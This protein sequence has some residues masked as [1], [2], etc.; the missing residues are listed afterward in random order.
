MLQH[1]PDGAAVRGATVSVGL[2]IHENCHSGLGKADTGRSRELEGSAHGPL[3][4]KGLSYQY[5]T[6][7]Y[8]WGHT[9][10]GAT[11]CRHRW[12]LDFKGSLEKSVAD[13]DHRRSLTCTH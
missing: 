6:D 8:W 11:K 2:H 12:P 9:L 3:K 5:V 4:E 13:S 1:D 10:G 7:I